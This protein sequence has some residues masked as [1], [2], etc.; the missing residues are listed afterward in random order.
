MTF[1]VE[2]VLRESDQTV[3]ETVDHGGG[4]PPGWTEADVGQ[5]L[6]AM[7]LA[8]HHSKYPQDGPD[9]TI[10]LRGLSWIVNPFNDGVVIALEIP[11]GAAVAG[12]FD[13]A[14]AR[15]DALIG[16]VIARESGGQG[17]QVH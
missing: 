6:R 10:A 14:P 13:I 15:L 3:T 7:L 4:E 11:M 16:R 12:P 8:I 5:V 9:P 2:I 17:T 1:R